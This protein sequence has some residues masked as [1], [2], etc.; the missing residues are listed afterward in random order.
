MI[1]P[2]IKPMTR[3]MITKAMSQPAGWNHPNLNLHRQWH[4]RHSLSVRARQALILLV[5]AAILMWVLSSPWWLLI[6]LLGLVWHPA[7]VPFRWHEHHT[8]EVVSKQYGDAYATA[9]NAP[10]DPFGFSKRLE[11]QAQNI[12]RNAELPNLPWLEVLVAAVIVSLVWLIPA[13]SA[14]QN[15]FAAGNE[16][17]LER[18]L[19]AETLPENDPGVTGAPVSNPAPQGQRQSSSPTGTG[20]TAGVGATRPGASNSG[21]APSSE[22]NE[23]ISRE[24]GQALER[25]AVR[26]PASTPTPAPKSSDGTSADER[27]ASSGNSDGSGNPSGISRRGSNGTRGSGSQSGNAQD[28]NG[29]KRD[30]PGQGSTSANGQNSP[31]SSQNQQQG[32]KNAP[33]QPS[34]SNRDN[35]GPRGLG[36]PGDDSAFTGNPAPGGSDPRG[37]R[38]TPG[39]KGTTGAGKAQSVPEANGAGKLEYLPGETK[40]NI[41]R[42]GAL[43]LPGDSSR[44]LP[45]G[46]GAEPYRRAAESA[47]L[48]PRLP[49]EYQE[50]L[51]QYYR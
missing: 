34:P 18:R 45:S 12:E 15:S 6:A 36:E 42:S 4:W 30:N 19:P 21:G 38:N 46:S 35:R 5:P 39:G 7:W 17:N 16:T 50:L 43:P 24:F 23:D 26:T 11:S 49:P 25:G 1:R 14:T 10:V 41:S 9:L 47:V 8:L 44:T 20:G 40:R 13:R 3:P 48:D 2:I 31:N 28:R 32:S 51:K 27:T 22:S 29:Q 33:G 37:Q